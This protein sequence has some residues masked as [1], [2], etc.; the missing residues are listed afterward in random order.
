[1]S[2]GPP[3]APG[4]GRPRKAEDAGSGQRL[5]KV[6]AEAA[7]RPQRAP[8]KDAE[9]SQRLAKVMAEAGISSRRGAEKMI[10]Q[11]RVRVNGQP[12]E[13]QGLK[14]D[15]ARDKITVDGRPLGPPQK[16]HY[17]M[18]HKPAGYLTTLSDPKGRP[19]IRRYLEKLPVRVF[20]VGRL[21][22]DVE[23]LLL[24]TND[25]A[26]AK[27]L[28]HPSSEVPK[29]YRVKVDG[30][31]G[32]EALKKLCDGTLRLGQRLAAPAKAEL[33]KSA[34]DRAWLYLTITEGRHHQVKRMCSAVGHPVLKLK[35]VAYGGLKLGSLKREAI[36]PL[37]AEEI[38]SLKRAVGLV[39]S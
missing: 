29:V 23:G 18:F 24:L 27:R 19:S 31:P 34:E 39:E 10:A 38:E 22:M 2:M 30:R 9:N 25:G 21:D 20:P 7:T 28:M 13:E 36:R 14:V 5:A 15:L 6:M 35:R 33:I 4:R 16:L 32:P 12:V 37:T 1:M 11:G 3:K 8:E 26:L 17:Y